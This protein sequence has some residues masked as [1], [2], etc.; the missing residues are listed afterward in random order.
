MDNEKNTEA[1][2]SNKTLQDILYRVLSEQKDKITALSVA[3]TLDQEDVMREVEVL[4]S[5]R[6]LL[7]ASWG[8][9]GSKVEINFVKR[10]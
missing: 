6:L 2:V 3:Q 10:S 9:N 7:D 5:A 4:R 1:E 8:M